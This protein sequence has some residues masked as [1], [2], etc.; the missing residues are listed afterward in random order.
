MTADELSM[1]EMLAAAQAGDEERFRAHAR[2]IMGHNQFDELYE[3]AQRFTRMLLARG[4]RFRKP[5]TSN[6]SE[7]TESTALRMVRGSSQLYIRAGCVLM[8]SKPRSKFCFVAAIYPKSAHKLSWHFIGL[9]S[10]TAVP[11]HTPFPVLI[12]RRN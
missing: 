7:P 9:R 6:A 1:V 12:L 4:H 11:G 8:E 5:D 10:R 3:S 2:W